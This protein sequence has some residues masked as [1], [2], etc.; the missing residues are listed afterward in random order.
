M[1]LLFAYGT[2]R[3]HAEGSPPEIAAAL[4]KA[5]R[6]GRATAP[7]RLHWMGAYPAMT[8]PAPGRVIGDVYRIDERQWPDVRPMLDSYEGGAYVREAILVTLET[9]AEM[10]AY[11]YLARDPAALGA[12]IEGGDFLA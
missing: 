12:C 7:G 5:E 11:A 1:P 3:P 9:G 10:K 6:L 8:T 4:A 2:L